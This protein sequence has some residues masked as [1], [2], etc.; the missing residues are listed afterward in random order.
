M[1]TFPTFLRPHGALVLGLVA[2]LSIPLTAQA[3]A[4]IEDERDDVVAVGDEEVLEQFV[5]P[6]ALQ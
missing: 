6:L 2:V 5:P 4:D 3:S 1:K